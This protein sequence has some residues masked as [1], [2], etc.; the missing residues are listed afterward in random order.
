MTFQDLRNDSARTFTDI[1]GEQFRN[2]EMA[3]GRI[4][5]INRPVALSVSETA[6]YVV[7]ASGMTTRVPFDPTRDVIRWRPNADAPHVQA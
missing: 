1:S 2:Y 6:H 3:D 4:L 7:D 5:T